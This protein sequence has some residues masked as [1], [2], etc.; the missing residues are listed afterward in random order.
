MPEQRKTILAI[1]D[2]I[3]I[4]ASIR[5]I[6][7]KSFDVSCAKNIEIAKTILGTTEV[8]LILLD[9]EIPGVSGMEFLE[10]LHKNSA[11]YH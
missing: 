6:L 3:T 9:M 1:D 5:S 2:D 8:D 7:T 10:T 11:F 4:L